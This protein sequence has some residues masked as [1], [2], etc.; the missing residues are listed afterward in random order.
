MHVMAVSI[1]DAQTA[2]GRLDFARFRSHLA[3]RLPRVRTYRER[4][5]TVPF[6]L[7]HP[8][9]IEDASFDLDRHL[10][11]V[12][13]ATP[14]GWAEL[15]ALVSTI[16]GRRLD[17]RLPLWSFTFVE[18]VDT[19]AGIPAGSVAL[20]AKVHHAAT[21]GLSGGE[22]LG[23]LLD[24]A[25]DAPS[26]PAAVDWH[27]P[28]A[29]GTVTLLEQAAREL[30]QTPAN[31]LDFAVAAARSAVVLPFVP[32]VAGVDALP[33]MYTAPHTSLNAPV[34][35]RRTWDCLPLS[36]A[37]VK[38]VKNAAGVSVNDVALA[39]CAGAIRRYLLAKDDLPE[40]AL[41]AMVPI[42][43]RAPA[44][45]EAMGNQ[46]SAILVK[47]ATEEAD[48]LV[49]LE[50]IRAEACQGKAN[51]RAM[52]AQGLVDGFQLVPY[53]LG[54]MGLRLYTATKITRYINPIFNCIITN[55][56]GSTEPLYMAGAP[57]LANMGLTPIFDAVALVITI[58]SYGGTLTF[59]VTACPELMPDID[60]F[61]RYL[62]DALT[63]LEC[64]LGLS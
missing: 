47:L 31:V 50:R 54:I 19:I 63:E 58:F 8:Y 53:G 34:S 24:M 33:W 37:R 55:I 56:P 38:A 51:N 5:V 29:P 28:P 44:A 43:T 12:T 27:P 61:V 4:L 52:D 46:V 6:G 1:F 45:R 57:M 42:S 18:G 35:A 23:A 59:S 62:S 48:P 15:R 49:R 13:L 2:D 9:W 21:D 11:H 36:L 26:G 17:R 14:G 22:M 20:I 16:F 10:Q 40:Q 7:G 41:I 39:V 64:A 30:L 32:H 60:S 3:V 25:Q